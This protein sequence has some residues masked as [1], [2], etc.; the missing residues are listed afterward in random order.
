MEQMKINKK[1]RDQI[2]K[3]LGFDKDDVCCHYCKEKIE[4]NPCGI[5]PAI[6]GEGAI[7]L[8]NCPMCVTEYLEDV[9]R[10]KDLIVREHEQFKRCSKLEMDS[11]DIIDK[12]LEKKKFRKKSIWERL[13]EW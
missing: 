5:F 1:Q 3:R 12:V 10:H 8:C 7:I 2:L 6:S 9:D 4:D 11:L 13:A